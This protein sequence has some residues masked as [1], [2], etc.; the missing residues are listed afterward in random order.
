MRALLVLV[1][2]IVSNCDVRADDPA[3]MLL[4][5]AGTWRTSGESKP[6]KWLPERANFTVR[7]NTR[8]VLKGRF[9]LGDEHSQPDG[10]KSLWLMTHDPQRN[11]YPFWMFDSTGLLGGQWELQWD[12]ASSTARGR[13]I[14]TPPG[15]TSGG[16]NH[17]TDRETNVVNYWMKDETG[18][19]L[20]DVHCVKK[21]QSE[22]D[23]E[24]I[25][26]EWSKVE[27][28]ADR[29]AELENLDVFV[30]I[31]DA[32]TV[33]RPAEWT[34]QEIRMTSVVTRQWIL[35][36]R[37][38]LDDSEHANG[39]ESLSIFGYDPQAREYRTWWFNSEGHRNS[40]RGRWD[41]ATQTFSFQTEPEAGRVTRGTIRLISPDQHEW[42][43]K[44]TDAAGK[45]YYD[46]TVTT[47][48]R[49]NGKTSE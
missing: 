24:S 14:D 12:A 49:K 8:S 28:A 33:A 31:W 43:F 32:V 4:R 41:P 36:K 10:R 6:S 22:T 15:W 16:T 47:A 25:L 17:F 3:G 34:P 45:V 30:G 29:P 42:Q 44:V 19:L 13:S 48:R 20:M 38:L 21:R 5:F 46:A 37:F 27:V 9:I 39:Q 1:L 7:E 26:A 11:I 23:G 18:A 35:N 40:S 2:L